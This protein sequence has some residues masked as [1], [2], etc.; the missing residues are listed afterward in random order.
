VTGVSYHKKSKRWLAKWQD[1]DGNHRSKCF[2]SKK[3]SNDI[4]KA[5]AIEHR[6]QMIRSLPH[7]RE[8]LCLDD[9]EA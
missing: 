9:A 3:Y 5:K 6:S 4:A 7:Y 8:A 1:R 2:S